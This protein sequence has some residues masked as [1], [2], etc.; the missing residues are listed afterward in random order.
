MTR[1]PRVPFLSLSL[2]LALAMI[3]SAA[4]GTEGGGNETGRGGS[5]GAAGSAGGARAG[6]GGGGSSG[7]AGA[8]GSGSSGAAGTG[9][10]AAGTGGRGGA[11]PGVAGTTGAAGSPAGAAG[12]GG[13]AGSGATAGS[14]GAGPGAAGRGGVSGGAGSGAAGTTG[15]GGAGAPFLTETFESGT[16]GMP[17]AGW[18]TFIAYVKNG[19][20]PNGGALAL[21]DD[22]QKH[23]G[24]RS[25]HFKG[26]QSPAMIT[27][28]LPSGTNK[29]YVRVWVYSSRKLGANNKDTNNHETMIGIRKTSGN[30]NDE[31]RFGE[32]KGAIGIN[33]VPTDAVSPPVAKW[34]MGASVPA[35]EWHCFEIAFL[36][37]QAATHSLH[38]WVDG[39]MVH[40]TVGNGTDQWHAPVPV[41][42]LN[43]KFNEVIL[44]WQSFSNQSADVWM[45]DLALSTGPI[46]CN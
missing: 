28:P 45:D 43:G 18:D 11:G 7:A 44:G 6:A 8:A 27:R 34:G 41:T 4:C 31:V 40:S 1:A 30:A 42:W 21:I 13:S 19:T 12:S 14:G 26:G 23:G 24:A 2:S 20:N 35:N 29:L 36:G 32:V 9:G 38:A 37:D 33:E 17:L 16:V 22:A 25:I 3:L 15:S 39:Q 10:S 46:G 5:S